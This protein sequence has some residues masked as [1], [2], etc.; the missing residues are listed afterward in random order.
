V[1]RVGHLTH[2]S[3]SQ[4]GTEA[5]PTSTLAFA[6]YVPREPNPR[7]ERLR[8]DQVDGVPDVT[9]SVTATRLAPYQARPVRR[10]ERR[11]PR[12]PPAPS[13]FPRPPPAVVVAGAR[14]RAGLARSRGAPSP[15]TSAVRP[16]TRAHMVPWE[17]MRRLY[18]G[19]YS[20]GD[21]PRVEGS[22]KGLGVRVGEHG[23]VEP[24]AQGLVHPG[25]GMSVAPDDPLF[26][27]GFRRPPEFLGS[28]GHPIWGIC[29]SDL[30]EVLTVVIDSPEHGV[31]GP[32][33]AMSLADYEAALAS[34]QSNWSLIRAE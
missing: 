23:D 13:L 33:R 3:F 10:R 26:L 28:A 11:G 25:A 12:R 9:R 1:A 4:L 27:P 17:P 2:G 5:E 19:M 16:P 14:P 31:I 22:A 34:T 29:E 6:R 15:T 20:D 21:H 8:R 32:A 30:P 7:G 18:R 24:D